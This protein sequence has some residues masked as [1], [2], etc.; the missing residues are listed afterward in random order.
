MSTKTETKSTPT[1]PEAGKPAAPAPAGTPAPVEVRKTVWQRLFSL[2][3]TAVLTVLVIGFS[4]LLGLSSEYNVIGGRFYRRDTAALDLRDRALTVERFEALQASMPGCAIRWSIPIGEGRYDSA[5][6]SIKITDFPAEETERFLL[7]DS[8]KSVDASDCTCYAALAGLR[9]LLPACEIVASVPIAGKSW[10]QDT[11]SLRI[12]AD[13][14]DYDELTERL[15]WLPALKTVRLP[16]CP[17][18]AEEQSALMIAYPSVTFL[19]P[20]TLCGRTFSSDA[21]SISFAG[22]K[23]MTAADLAELREN[24]FRFYALREIDLTD[25]GFESDELL[26]LG[27]ALGV[28][29]IWSFD[30]CGVTVSTADTQIDLSPAAGTVTVE[31]VEAALPCFFQLQKVDMCGCGIPDEEMEALNRRHEGIQ[32]VWMVHI[33]TYGVRTDAT[34][35]IVYN[36][37]NYLFSDAGVDALRYCTRLEA[38]DLGHMRVTN[39]DFLQYM[40]HLKYLI[41]AETAL[42]DLTEVGK[43]KEITWLEL[44]QMPVRDFSPLLGCTALKDL[45][46]CYIYGTD[47][48]TEYGILRQMTWLKRLWFSGNHMSAEQTAA[49]QKDLPDCEMQLTLGDDSTG[50]SWRYHDDYYAMRDAF[51]MYYMD[52]EGNRTTEKKYGD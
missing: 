5:A 16:E 8:L 24:A 42:S 22:Q 34:Y 14:A 10:P 20:V 38:L 39:L 32:F 49:L 2:P 47:G 35:F 15:A 23:G 44:F 27:K 13:A 48:D 25:C 19:W 9:K 51:H 6:E 18:T 40:P 52:A 41:L 1:D 11:E 4:I 36:C 7:F 50:G 29:V 21:E 33:R 28:H 46:L 3:G 12:A 37:T 43:L 26:A 30:L 31:A 45:N 17:F